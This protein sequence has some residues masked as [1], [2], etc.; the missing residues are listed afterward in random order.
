VRDVEII[1]NNPEMLKK[2]K[3]ERKNRNNYSEYKYVEDMLREKL[4]TRVKI[5]EKRIKINF[6]NVNDLNRILEI[7]NIKE[8]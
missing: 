6:S 7:L 4:D 3:M 5:K 1:S 2:V 8:Q